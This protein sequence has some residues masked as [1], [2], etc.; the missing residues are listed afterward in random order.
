MADVADVDDERERLRV[1][2]LDN[3]IQRPY[4]A[5]RIRNVAQHA[6]RH[7]ALGKGRERGGGA[8]R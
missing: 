6:E 2:L 5:L 4:F 7:R 1:H 3:A 8:A